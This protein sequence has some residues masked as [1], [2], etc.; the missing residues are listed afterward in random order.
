MRTV[1]REDSASRHH[2]A[3]IKATLKPLEYLTRMMKIEAYFKVDLL[4]THD[5]LLS[6]KVDYSRLSM[7]AY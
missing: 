3:P 4:F 2:G 7:K 5:K 1:V 6:P